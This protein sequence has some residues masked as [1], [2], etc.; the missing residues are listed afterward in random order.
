MRYN[1]LAVAALLIIA[2]SGALGASATD[3]LKQQRSR[4]NNAIAER[5][6]LLDRIHFTGHNGDSVQLASINA[7]ELTVAYALQALEN[8]IE[9]V[10]PATRQKNGR[11]EGGLGR[12]SEPMLMICQFQVDQMVSDSAELEDSRIRDEV[13]KQIDNVRAACS[14]I[15]A[16]TN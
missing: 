8:V 12:V 16:V 4:I 9:L 1:I 2:T 3:S 7:S 11:R 15:V 13:Q 10:G 5:N 14:A 6:A